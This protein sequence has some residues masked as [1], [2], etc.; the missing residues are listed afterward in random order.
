MTPILFS[1]L[2]TIVT[3]IV[4]TC[5]QVLPKT[6]GTGRPRKIAWIDA[7]AFALYQHTSTRATKKSVWSDFKKVLRCA[8]STFVTAINEAAVIALRILFIVMRTNRKSAHLLKFTDATD[9]PVCLAKNG[10]RHRTMRGL[11]SWG[12]SGKRSRM[13]LLDSQLRRTRCTISGANFFL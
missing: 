13:E 8:Y 11:A 12:H 6:P 3:Q 4:H 7:L 2:K 9:I 1:Q 10:K 5:K